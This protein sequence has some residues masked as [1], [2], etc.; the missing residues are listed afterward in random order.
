MSA[1]SRIALTAL[2]SAALIA[3]TAYSA[4]RGRGGGGGRGGGA[5]MGRAQG[6]GGGGGARFQGGGTSRQQ[7]QGVTR[8]FSGSSDRGGGSAQWNRGGDGSR[9]GKSPQWDRGGTSA[10]WNRS[11]DWNRGSA[12]SQGKT[13]DRDWDRGDKWSGRWDHNDGHYGRDGYRS[14]SSWSPWYS[15]GWWPG[16]AYG[17]RG[18]GYPYY[19]DYYYGGDPYAYSYGYSAPY[20]S[21]YG[22]TDVMVDAPAQAGDFY[23]QALASFRRGDFRDAV[24]LAGHA[25]IDDPE[26]P[27]VHLLLSLTLFAT[28]EYRGAAMEAHAVAALGKIPD[29]ATVFGIY[30]NVDAYTVHLR[31]LEKQVRENPS[32]AEA[33]FLLGFQYMMAGHRDAARKE[34]SEAVR[35]EPKD[36]LASRL[37]TDVG[38]KTGEAGAAPMREAEPAPTNVPEVPEAPTDVEQQSEQL[39][40]AAP[41]SAEERPTE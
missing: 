30:S 14:F 22:S 35:L 17:W 10:Q 18:S 39:E 24:R 33:R 7:S 28:G 26:N 13:W 16:Y 21:A 5:S 29:W 15:F 36:R 20:T 41:H 2:L 11:G 19:G 37:L 12:W 4:E 40:P 32:S 34:L 38:G 6:G 25:S 3:A 31:A 27:A 23:S 9:G 1:K 8:Q